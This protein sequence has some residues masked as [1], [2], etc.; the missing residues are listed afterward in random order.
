MKGIYMKKKMHDDLTEIQLINRRFGMTLKVSLFYI[1]HLLIDTGTIRKKEQLLPVFN[2]WDIEQVVVTH[3][4]EDHSGLAYWLEE[5]KDLKIYGH[6]SGVDLGRSTKRLPFYRRVFWG[7]KKPYNISPLQESFQTNRYTWDVI[8][9]PGHAPD[10]IALFN[11]EKKWMFGGD[12]Y[13]Q[14]QPK[15][16]FSFESVPTLIQS[17]K[18]LLTYDFSIYICS[19]VGV[20]PRGREAI[21]GK[22]NY[23]KM[24]QKNILTLHEAGLS[25]NNIRKKLLPERHPLH[26]LSFLDNSPKHMIRSV[27]RD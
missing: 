6:Y 24:M 27:L 13:V 15:S 5:N 22:L 2:E 16:M 21:E 11:R 7:P 17:L 8:H 9:T 26:Y 18:T 10:H 3:H 25:V 4:H 12:L 23:L 14:R 19:H 20:I 1:D